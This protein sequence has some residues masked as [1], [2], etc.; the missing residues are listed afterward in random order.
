[1][2]STPLATFETGSPGAPAIVFLHGGGLSGRQWEPQLAQLQEFHCLAPDLPEQGRSIHLA[3]FTLEGAASAVAELIAQRVPSGRAHVVGLS[4]G[5]AVGLTLLRTAPQAVSS[6][7]VTGTAAGLGRTLGAISMWSAG[8]YRVLPPRLLAGMA[9]RQFGIP[10]EYADTFR[11]DMAL[12]TTAAF[13][14]NYTRALM[15]M[16]LPEEVSVPVLVAV[17]QRETVV[18]RRAAQK[19]V[20]RIPGAQGVQVPAVGH[21]WNLEAPALFTETVRA[22]IA[23]E[24]LPP[25]LIR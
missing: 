8:L 19:L 22:W 13:T 3:P 11:E 21:V 4:L 5:G 25:S 10:A 23:G 2:D 12:S 9:V 1:M 20:R 24:P 14:R 7:F 15:N 6:L 17:G 16:V 18:A